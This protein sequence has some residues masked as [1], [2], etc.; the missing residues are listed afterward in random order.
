MK[1]ILVVSLLVILTACSET[2]PVRE[3]PTGPAG[4][5]GPQ[6]PPGPRGEQGPPG[7]VLLSDGGTAIGPPGPRGASVVVSPVPPGATCPEG[8]VRV[9]VEDDGSFSIVCHGAPGAAGPAGPAGPQGVQGPA[10]VAGPMGPAGPAGP[11]GPQGPQGPA[12]V[13]TTAITIAKGDANCPYG[14]TRFTVGTVTTYAC[15]GAP[16]AMGPPGPPGG[17]GGDGGYTNALAGGYAFTGFTSATYDGNLGG[18]LGANQKCHA[19]FPG[20]YFCTDREYQWIG[21]AVP[22]P[23]GGAWI[24]DANYP[25]QYSPALQPRDRSG[26]E[27]CNHWRVSTSGYYGGYLDAD[28]YRSATSTACVTPRPLACC[29]SRQA[30]FR[31]FTSA[32]Y[33]GNLGGV[34]GANMKCHAEFPGSHF[35]TD[36]EYQWAGSSTSI[37]GGG[38]WIDDASYPTQYSPSLSPRDRSGSETCN[39]WRIS[40]TGYHGGYLDQ[41]GYRAATSTACTVPRPLACCG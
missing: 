1:R 40:T 37:P 32:S 2:A 31:G 12:G 27:T 38:A 13:S 9:G 4:P 11:Q 34:L 19:E 26:D 39:N 3:G 23:T 10:G 30:I 33:D 6:G 18:V 28:G 35:C 29:R 36:R 24:D 17:G 22:T 14:G 41:D 8:G 16:G 20:A 21:P 5:E 15:N 25:S 7:E